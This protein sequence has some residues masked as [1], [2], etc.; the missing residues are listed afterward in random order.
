MLRIA[1]E[2]LALPTLCLCLSVRCCAVAQ[3]CVAMPFRVLAELCAIALLYSA[4]LCLC[5]TVLCSAWPLQSECKQCFAYAK[6]I[7]ALAEHYLAMPSRDYALPVHLMAAPL[8]R[9]ALLCLCWAFPCSACAIRCKQLPLPRVSMQCFAVAMPCFSLPWQCRCF[10]LH[11]SA[12]AWLR[13]ALP[14]RGIGRGVS[15]ALLYT[16]VLR[17]REVVSRPGA[18][19][20]ARTNTHAIISR[21][22]CQLS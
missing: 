9:F 12:F 4:I 6:R 10:A 22:L 2:R 8:L 21:A 14:L 13:A 18:D 3:L 19:C 15:P 17:L 20:W 16:S 11:N 7:T 5:V 1:K